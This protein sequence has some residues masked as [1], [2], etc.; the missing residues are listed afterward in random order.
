M[1]DFDKLFAK[2][3]VIGVKN[4]YKN[5]IFPTLIDNITSTTW[6]NIFKNN[7]LCCKD[8]YVHIDGVVYTTDFEVQYIIRLDK[9]GNVVERLFDRERDI[10][11]DEPMPELKTGMFGKALFYN[12]NGEYEEDDELFG[13]FVVLNDKIVYQNGGWDNLEGLLNNYNLNKKNNPQIV[14]IYEQPKS[15]RDANQPLW[16]N[17]NY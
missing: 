8:Q 15:F 6:L 11:K 14:E 5:K 3:N 1:W 17:P 10:P 12:K 7:N 4:C 13:K 2:G 16:R 9:H